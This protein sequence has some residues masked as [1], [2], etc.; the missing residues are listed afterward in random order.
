MHSIIF[1]DYYYSF[2]HVFQLYTNSMLSSLNAR[3]SFGDDGTTENV[4]TEVKL[5]LG[6]GSQAV[7]AHGHLGQT[8]VQIEQY[9]LRDTQTF[10]GLK[11]NGFVRYQDT[12]LVS[13]K[14]L[15]V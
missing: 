1:L 6:G 3:N 10:D 2:S 7:D 14:V 12:S 11:A 8:C 4:G 13:Q 15:N 9:E 5:N